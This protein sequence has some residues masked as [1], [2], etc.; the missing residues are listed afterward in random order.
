MTLYLRFFPRKIGISPLKSSNLS[1]SKTVAEGHDTDN[2]LENFA[3]TSAM[4]PLNNLEFV[5]DYKDN[6]SQ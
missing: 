2:Y 6:G 1:F 3:R 4:T 5:D